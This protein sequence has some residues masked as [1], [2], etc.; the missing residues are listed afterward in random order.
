MTQSGLNRI[1]LERLF[2]KILMDM[3]GEFDKMITQV[4]ISKSKYT[5]T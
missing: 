3:P 5:F 1:G 4:S 2:C